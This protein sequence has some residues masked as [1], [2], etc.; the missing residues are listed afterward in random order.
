MIYREDGT[1]YLEWGGK[2]AS[3]LKHELI[4]KPSP[5]GQRFDKKESDAGDHFI[6]D[7]KGNLQVRDNDGLISNA[8]ALPAPT[9]TVVDPTPTP[10]FAAESRARGDGI[11]CR[12]LQQLARE[13]EGGF[14]AT[15]DEML[16][17]INDNIEII[18]PFSSPGIRDAASG[19]RPPLEAGDTA[20]FTAAV[21][22]LD[23]AC[24][25]I[26]GYD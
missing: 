5:L 12:S 13:V 19:L 2:G 4:E 22:D 25:K 18:A 6:I 17:F 23:D 15:V 7:R 21:N 20:G 16:Q 10:D 26:G 14:M 9:P 11:V 1:L 24:E 3:S 8:A